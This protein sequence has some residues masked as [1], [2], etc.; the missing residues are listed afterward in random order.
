MSSLLG[1]REGI[2]SRL[3][4]SAGLL[5]IMG[6]V[7]V[8]YVFPDEEEPPLPYIVHRL[9][10]GNAPD[11]A[12]ERGVW[13]CDVW[14]YSDTATRAEQIR[15]EIIRLYDLWQLEGVVGA[16]AIRFFKNSVGFVPDTEVGIWHIAMQFNVRF[17]RTADVTA[18]LAR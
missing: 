14:D 12:I 16:N 7:R 11:A 9:D 18:I 15:D 3:T 6:A 5:A 10:I 17:A 2:Y 1:V 13:Y 4:T 8:H